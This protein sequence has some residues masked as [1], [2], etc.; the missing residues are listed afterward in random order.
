MKHVPFNWPVEKSRLFPDYYSLGKAFL[1]AE[2]IF[3][4]IEA[5][6]VFFCFVLFFPPFFYIIYEHVELNSFLRGTMQEGESVLRMSA[7]NEIPGSPR[8]ML[9]A[10]LRAHTRDVRRELLRI[11][12][13]WILFN[14]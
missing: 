10:L 7:Y 11:S 12:F 4:P 1:E 14:I 5:R 6:G 9:R 3:S 2:R 8:I 13:R